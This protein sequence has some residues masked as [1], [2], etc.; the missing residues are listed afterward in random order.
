MRKTLLS[1]LIL[2]ALANLTACSKK[3]H[4]SF[5]GEVEEMID[6]AGDEMEDLADEFNHE[7]DELEDN[8]ED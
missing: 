6:D 3:N 4:D 8:F 1:L 7:L 5:S 2:L